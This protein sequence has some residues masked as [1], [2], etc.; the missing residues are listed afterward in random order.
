MEEVK[1]KIKQQIQIQLKL[2]N[3]CI[4][5]EEKLKIANTLCRLL[6]AYHKTERP[7]YKKRNYKKDKGNHIPRIDL[8]GN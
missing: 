3:R 2:L 1:L 5:E 8:G 6:D 4:Q 7:Y